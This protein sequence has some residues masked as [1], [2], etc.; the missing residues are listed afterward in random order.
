MFIEI[1]DV[2]TDNINK[3]SDNLKLNNYNNYNNTNSN[4]SDLQR[5]TGQNNYN[6]PSLK[7]NDTSMNQNFKGIIIIIKVIL[8]FHQTQTYL[9]QG[10]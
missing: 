6:R 1:R 7:D 9:T 4:Y 10:T 2:S 8:V 5:Y 3:S